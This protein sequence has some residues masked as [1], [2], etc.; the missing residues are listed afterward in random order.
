MIGIF[1]VLVTMVFSFVIQQK[2]ETVIVTQPAQD[3]APVHIAES[4]LK[5][6][7]LL[8]YQLKSGKIDAD[9]IENKGM[10]NLAS[11][12]ATAVNK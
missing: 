7:F 5:K 3:A 9:Q 10:L 6:A 12:V 11:A 1:F 8:Q 4:N 2:K